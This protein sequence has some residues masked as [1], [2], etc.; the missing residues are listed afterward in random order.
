[1]DDIKSMNTTLTSKS[2]FKA[3][4][5][6]AAAGILVW[7]VQ[8][9][10]KNGINMEETRA[11]RTFLKA[12]KG[13]DTSVFAKNLEGARVMGYGPKGYLFVSATSAGRIYAIRDIND[14]GTADESEKEQIVVAENLDRPHGFAIKCPEHEEALFGGVPKECKIFIA[15]T[16]N[17]SVYDLNYAALKTKNKRK[18]MDLPPEGNHFTRTV[19]FTPEEKLLVSI[20]SSCNVCYEK[21]E[22][23]AAVLLVDPET[24]KWE[25]FRKGLRNAVFMTL[26][27][28]NGKVWATEM[29]RDFLGDNLPPD[30]INIL[31]LNKK[32]Q[33]YGWPECY[34]KNI[35]DSVFHKNNH[36]HKRPHCTVP[37]EM[38]S[39][40]DIPAHSAPLGL[41]FFPEEG[42]PKEYWFNLLVAYHGSWNRSTPTGYKIVRFKLDQN[43]NPIEKDA[44]GNAVAEDFITG[45]LPPGA[46]AKSALGRPVDILIQPGG[47]IFLS[48]DK[49]NAI[50][51]VVKSEN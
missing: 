14:D 48:D 9:S 2:L 30:E 4:V 19:I 17:L 13:F 28:V 6:L 10:Q 44:Q 50:Y 42:W 41:A 29:G 24:G 12:P 11:G 40:I 3:L 36:P 31:D 37:Q 7:L 32:N 16:G 20:G 39:H 5:A 27:P 8:T 47:T 33:N 49:A 34:G 43:G 21:D 51:R 45:F 25:V 18:I 26:H 22:R 35:L 1:M 23:R 38:P 46:P 15:E